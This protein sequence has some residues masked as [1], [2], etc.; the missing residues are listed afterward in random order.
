M[1]MEPTVLK[2]CKVCCSNSHDLP[3][4]PPAETVSE[5]KAKG[6]ERHG[7]WTQEKATGGWGQCV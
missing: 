3:T 5:V 6:D 2:Y 7:S 4:T 1:Y